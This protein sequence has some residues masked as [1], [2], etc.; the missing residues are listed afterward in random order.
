MFTEFLQNFCKYLMDIP[1]E[2]YIA[3]GRRIHRDRKN[4]S[5]PAYFCGRILF[6]ITFADSDRDFLYK[7]TK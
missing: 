3:T 4:A 5:A 6:I 1:A 7:R 2:E